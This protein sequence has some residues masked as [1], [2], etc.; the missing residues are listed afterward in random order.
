[1]RYRTSPVLVGVVVV[2][3]MCAS[4]SGDELNTD[5]LLRQKEIA[6]YWKELRKR[7]EDTKP[8]ILK[9]EASHSMIARETSADVPLAE[10]R[11]IEESLHQAARANPLVGD[12]VQTSPLS[13]QPWK[14][15]SPVAP[16][17]VESDHATGPD[18]S[19]RP[20][21]GE[22]LFS[23]V[24]V[25]LPVRGDIG[26]CFLRTYSSHI[27]YNGPLGT[28]WDH[29]LNQR[30]EW[31]RGDKGRPDSLRW[32]V[33]NRKV[34]F[35]RVGNEWDPEPGEHWT[36]HEDPK[37]VKTLK[38]QSSSL[39][40]FVFEEDSSAST[41]QDPSARKFRLS[42]IA[43]RTRSDGASNNVDLKYA[44]NGGLLTKV[45]DPYGTN[46]E[47]VY[48]MAGRIIQLHTPIGP[49]E[50]GYNGDGTLVSAK[51]PASSL[52]VDSKTEPT[53]ELYSYFQVGGR[54]VMNTVGVLGAPFV[55]EYAYDPDQ[56]APLR[57]VA[58]SV[59][60]KTGKA[61]DPKAG[62]RFQY[63][64][65]E[66][67]T[68]LMVS[69]T[70]PS[71]QPLIKLTYPMKNGVQQRQP[72][73]RGI[74]AWGDGK[75]EFDYD[76]ELH[77]IKVTTPTKVI[78]R[79]RFDVNNPDHALRG[80][81]LGSTRE[82][83]LKTDA[84]KEI[85]EKFVYQEH[86]GFIKS[87]EC[88]ENPRDKPEKRLSSDTFEFDPVTLDVIKRSNDGVE[89]WQY[90]NRFGELVMSVDA[91]GHA[92]IT[93]YSRIASLED[94]AKLPPFGD[95]AQVETGHA[96]GGGLACMQID[97]AS[98]DQRDALLREINQVFPLDP[99]VALL[100]S[101]QV[102]THLGYDRLG[103][104]CWSKQ[105]GEVE[106]V[107]LLLLSN[108]GQLLA[109]FETGMGVTLFDYM[110]WGALKQERHEFD[111][112]ADAQFKGSSSGSFG[113]R[114][115]WSET[116][117]YDSQGHLTHWT[118]TDE[119]INGNIATFHYNR[120]PDGSLKE[121]TDPDGVVRINEVD[122]RTGLLTGIRV[123]GNDRKESAILLADRVCDA[124]GELKSW[125]DEYGG[126]W[127]RTLDGF[128][129]E[130]TRR[131]PMDFETNMVLDGL[132]RTRKSSIN[133][134]DGPDVAQSNYEFGFNGLL[135]RVRVSRISPTSSGVQ[136][137]ELVASEYRYDETGALIASRAMRQ[138]AESWSV[139][140]S[141][142]LGEVVG[143]SLPDGTISATV[144]Q[145]GLRGISGKKTR[146]TSVPSPA[147][148][149]QVSVAVHDM[150]RHLW[151]EVPLEFGSMPLYARACY[152]Q[153]DVSGNQVA[154]SSPETTTSGFR[155]DT[156]GRV[157]R[158]EISPTAGGVGERR[159]TVYEF[160]PGNRPSRTVTANN[161]LLLVA[162]KTGNE[163]L[164]PE[165]RSVDQVSETTY[166]ALGRASLEIA[167]DGL[168]VKTD[169]D[170]ERGTLPRRRSWLNKSLP[171][172]PALRD[173]KFEFDSRG[174]ILSIRNL[175]SEGQL[176]RMFKY[177]GL[178]HCVESTDWEE[179]Q[180][181]PRFIR[182]HRDYDSLGNLLAEKVETE[183]GSLPILKLTHDM[184]K[185]V[186]LAEWD[187]L[188]GIGVSGWTNEKRTE[189][190]AGRLKTIALCNGKAPFTD[191]AQFKYERN[192]C[193]ELSLPSAA[194]VTH[195]EYSPQDELILQKL[196]QGALLSESARLDYG[197]GRHGQLLWK[198]SWSKVGQK[199]EICEQSD[200]MDYDAFEQVT[201]TVREQKRDMDPIG[202]R[203][204]V[205]LNPTTASFI[206][207]TATRSCFDSTSNNWLQYRGKPVDL[208]KIQS[209]VLPIAANPEYSTPAS[210][211][212]TPANVA[213]E[214]VCRELASNRVGKKASLDPE[215]SK[216]VKQSAC[217][218]YDKLGNLVEFD[219]RY[220]NG[221]IQFP[222][223]WRLTFDSL[224]RLVQ[225][226]GSLR[227]AVGKHEKGKLAATLRFQYD[228]ENRRVTQDVE[229][230]LISRRDKTAT[231]YRAQNQSIL[232]KCVDADWKCV[233][234]DWKVV[235]QYLWGPASRQLLL[236]TLN[237]KDFEGGPQTGMDRYWFL[238]DCGLSVVAV[239][240]AVDGVPVWIE[241]ASYSSFGRNTTLG[242]FSKVAT[243]GSGSGVSNEKAAI[244]NNLDGPSAKWTFLSEK[245][246]RWIELT[247]DEPS[248]IQELQVWAKT[249]PSQY[250]IALLPENVTAS[251]AASTDIKV[252]KDTILALGEQCVTAEAT[253]D[254]RA[255]QSQ[256][257]NGFHAKRIV[258]WWKGGLT[259]LD[260]SEIE[261]TITPGS[262]AGIAF[263]GQ[264]LDQASGLYYQ[265]NRYR[266]PELGTFIS[267]DPVGFAA[268]ANLY[269]Y[270]NNNPTKWHDPDG[271]FWQSITG[272]VIGAV[273]GVV[274]YTTSAWLNDE[275]FSFKKLGVH[276]AAGTAGGIVLASTGNL[277]AA[278]ATEGAILGGG[279][280]YLEGG[281]AKDI[282]FA[283]AT[284][285][286]LGYVGGAVMGKVGD[287]IKPFADKL[288]KTLAS[289]VGQV[290]KKFGTYARPTGFVKGVKAEVWEA[291]KNPKSGR[292][293]DPLTGRFM[294]KDDP[295]DMGHKPGYEF[296]KHQQSAV[297]RGITRS[298]FVAEH[299]NPSH[300]HPEL[301]ASNRSHAG[302]DMTSTYFGP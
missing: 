141:D 116:L 36:V 137:E 67:S 285:A 50:Y 103:R 189:D 105:L 138:E 20:E 222:V 38:I 109:H 236:G 232:L 114:R 225:M 250:S 192:L 279:L 265:I 4:T 161:P 184:S 193:T 110:P 217:Y 58:A 188:N 60:D 262:S 227:D 215:N 43:G 175:L 223:T 267:P 190:V 57:V 259:Q 260:V 33:S 118:E 231:L 136:R 28:G 63:E 214:D 288:N 100:P 107:R 165:R 283:T 102:K 157:V 134:V 277:R 272:G 140:L 117:D 191:E 233:D 291:A 243:S 95:I 79:D 276:V 290:K 121:V 73:R 296:R 78:V 46:L 266:S 147:L 177:D 75:W 200:Y 210:M 12:A 83:A 31:I 258:I 241:N 213:T 47:F 171:D 18:G 108:R 208:N 257:L 151:M 254:V 81:L 212:I 238:Q 52:G 53:G 173:L 70:Q 25:A 59:K 26:L 76:D 120:F 89:H 159:L 194:L 180:S 35:T 246:F 8:V 112:R 264:W 224:G 84:I 230:L 263:A 2:M 13:F 278:A 240:K 77:R 292:V 49:I 261:L 281:S 144:T 22:L 55:T 93:L 169:Y 269:A 256:R 54:S 206:A 9:S 251:P 90:W 183:T 143:Q 153:H 168:I 14:R 32:F 7:E 226:N 282:A 286:A 198:Q 228:A 164:T 199:Q 74:P 94:P 96:E 56:N 302:E 124:S 99:P 298:E 244:D 273:W 182:V 154:V 126:K 211:D 15:V 146:A 145:G 293:H 202:R 187:G 167:P 87:H 39:I 10:F 287:V 125:T 242:R 220:S 5:I 270:A 181:T 130:V 80:N 156:R 142:G 23:R 98:V 82:S 149:E 197:F 252:W 229:D 216:Q 91:L 295:W 129:R 203:E 294:S 172:A 1:M 27:D 245:P 65:D 44:P 41:T 152:Y 16:W 6:T 42:R 131:D 19:V 163:V 204:E 113:E 29:N 92:D 155:F 176:L 201:A 128:G 51:W 34:V 106:R 119:P 300:Y 237:R 170:Q 123:T 274:T 207:T 64:P 97:D 218:K 21:S 178:G 166:D 135:E 196:T 247:L 186:Q 271:R 255:A 235:D 205:L 185:G 37:D 104:L 280:A 66:T 3:H 275:E 297:D 179:P 162:A 160:T 148:K 221:V 219:G 249:F 289:L 45:S 139:F 239:A 234:A 61:I 71:P 86:T 115:F 40:T 24:D 127:E 122:D 48:D 253:W 72:S 132:G 301:P 30:V 268:G 101:A 174:R 284:G 111:A 195:Y 209:L 299:N 248:G 11:K 88:F 85:N 68:E 69:I 62:W 150:R 158:E 133:A 17:P